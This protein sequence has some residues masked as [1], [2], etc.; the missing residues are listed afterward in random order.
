VNLDG[1]V[2]DEGLPI[3]PGVV[4]STWSTVS[5]PGTVA[6]G[7]ASA[8]DTTA[9]FSDPGTY[10]LRLSAD[11]GELTSTD[12]VTITLVDANAAPSVDAG[13]DQTISLPTT[14]VDWTAR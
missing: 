1:T 11:D 13:P 10:V 2:T 4:T 8:V 7:D 12:D 14:T 5:G 3:P 9:A 6:F